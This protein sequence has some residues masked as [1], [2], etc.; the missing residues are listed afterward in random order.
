MKFVFIMSK[1]NMNKPHRTNTLL[2]WAY[3]NLYCPTSTYKV[4][5]HEVFF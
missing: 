2:L 4:K 1:N 3:V 5:A